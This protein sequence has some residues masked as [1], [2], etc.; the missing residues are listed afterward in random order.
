MMDA[1]LAYAAENKLDAQRFIHK[2]IMPNIFKCK[3]KS[4]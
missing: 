2:G 4:R 3:H 1:M